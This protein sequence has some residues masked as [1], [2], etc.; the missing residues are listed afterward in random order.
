[1]TTPALSHLETLLPMLLQQPNEKSNDVTIPLDPTKEQQLLLNAITRSPDLHADIPIYQHKLIR[2]LDQVVMIEDKHA[3]NK[4]QSAFYDL[5]DDLLMLLQTDFAQYM[6]EDCKIPTSYLRIVQE[7][8]YEELPVISEQFDECDIDPALQQII[9]HPFYELMK[10]KDSDFLYSYR[11]IVYLQKLAIELKTLKNDNHLK[12]ILLVF[13]FNDQACIRYLINAIKA[14]IEEKASLAGQL[15]TIRDF[16]KDIQQNWV[17]QGN[18]FDRL[19]EPISSQ[20]LN[21]LSVEQA[22]LESLSYENNSTSDSTPWDGFKIRTNFTVLQIG[23]LFGVFM[24]LK[25]ILNDDKKELATFLATFMT[26][27]KKENFNS[28]YLRNGFYNYDPKVAKS[29]IAILTEV[30]REL[31]RY[32]N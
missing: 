32:C 20:M 25:M 13:D 8:F 26:S 12:E 30:I 1:M 9:L 24:D 16:Q 29:V 15:Q 3:L 17:L 4:S 22:H 11:D 5:L 7:I 19:Q 28:G 6:D 2:M 10:T 23:A 18:C 14:S 31:R 21:W 27:D